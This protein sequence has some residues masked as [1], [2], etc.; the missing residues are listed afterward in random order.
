M[1][2]PQYNLFSPERHAKGF[3]RGMC[4]YV[5][6]ERRWVSESNRQ[7]QRQKEKGVTGSKETNLKKKTVIII[8]HHARHIMIIMIIKVRKPHSRV[9]MLC[10]VLTCRRR[11]S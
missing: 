6:V 1:F 7:E 4:V 11:E 8:I 2:L 3:E 9:A 5:S 10:A